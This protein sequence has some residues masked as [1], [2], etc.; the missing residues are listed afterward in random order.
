[1][2][3]AAAKRSRCGEKRDRE[4]ASIRLLTRAAAE[5]VFHLSAE[6]ISRTLGSRLA[7][8]CCYGSQT[9]RTPAAF[10]TETRPSAA[11]AAAI[12]IPIPLSTGASPS[13]TLTSSTGASALRSSA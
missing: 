6:S 13:G 11:G 7:I 12:P 9:S 4:R 1:M 5:A 2:E 8:P 3:A 10:C